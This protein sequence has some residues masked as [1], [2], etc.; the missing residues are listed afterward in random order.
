MIRDEEIRFCDTRG[1]GAPFVFVTVA[2]ERGERFRQMPVNAEADP[3]GN[4]AVYRDSTERLVGRVLARGTLPSGHETL[5]MPHFAT[6]TDPDAHRRRQR[7]DYRRAQSAHAARQRTA[8]SQSALQQAW[9]TAG[10]RI[11]P[12]GRGG[13]R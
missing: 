12:P 2:N 8:R 5:F 9:P 10:Y 11:L 4:V 3:A 6:C 1:C 13:G 7:D